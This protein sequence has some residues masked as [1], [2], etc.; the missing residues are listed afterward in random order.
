MSIIWVLLVAVVVGH[1]AD[2]PSASPTAPSASPDDGMLRAELEMLRKRVAS[3]TAESR[4]M[5]EEIRR[6]RSGA[7]DQRV[8]R[9]A[10][11]DELR[12]LR[13]SVARLEEQN[14]MLS[15]VLPGPFT[16][17]GPGEVGLIADAGGDTQV[18][19]WLGPQAA[20]VRF[21]GNGRTVVVEAGNATV[22][23][24]IKVIRPP[25]QAVVI[26]APLTLSGVWRVTG[27]R[28]VGPVQGAEVE[29][30]VLTPAY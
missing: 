2:A 30:P 13:D 7:A 8:D 16:R 12:Q 6:L 17:F 21:R 22:Q 20:L 3:L 15:A 1:P 24:Q 26:D 14:A 11:N 28:K 19:D 27:K 10:D 23:K 4:K 5:A 9:A 18:I 29:Y 25:P